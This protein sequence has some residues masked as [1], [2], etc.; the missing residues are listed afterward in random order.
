ML[1]SREKYA[2]M[3]RR[4]AEVKRLKGKPVRRG[5]FVALRDDQDAF[6]T[7]TAARMGRSK[8]AVIRECVDAYWSALWDAESNAS[9][10]RQLSPFHK[11][12]G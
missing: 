12:K 2:E 6:V 7:T 3:G 5:V 10:H 4:S 9:R 8:A 1:H 11:P